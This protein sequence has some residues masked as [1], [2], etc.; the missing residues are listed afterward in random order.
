MSRLIFYPNEWASGEIRGRQMAAVVGGVVDAN[1]VHSDD[2]LI[3]IKGL[4]SSRIVNHVR[5][6]YIDVDDGWGLLDVLKTRLEVT[7]I[8]AS[9]VGQ[10]YLQE[11][12]GRD[13][14]LLIPGHHCNFERDVKVV[15]VIKT[16]GFIGYPENLQLGIDELYRRLGGVGINFVAKT[17][18]KSREDVCNF[19]KSID[20]QICFRKKSEM[21]PVPELRDPLKL[22]NAG[23]FGIPTVAY[24]EPTYA[25]EFNGCFVPVQS[26]Y[27]VISACEYLSCVGCL[28]DYNDISMRARCRAEHYHIDH[29]APLFRGLLDES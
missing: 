16:A 22:I 23:S 3:F 10:K 25:D 27:E 21:N 12:L 18:A 5:K 6:V 17:D 8:A 20:I 28:P 9:R 11:Q 24:P 4:P 15:G 7:P 29:I 2:V 1:E 26:L 13:D 14:V 19:Y